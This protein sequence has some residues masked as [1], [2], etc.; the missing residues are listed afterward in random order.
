[1]VSL[2]DIVPATETVTVQGQ[3]VAVQGV[4]ATGVAHLLGRF[5]EIRAM[6][7]GRIIDPDKLVTMGGPIVAAIIAAGCG[8]AGNAD[9]ERI[10]GSLGVDEQA[11]LLA[12]ILR[13][14]LPQGVGPFVEK[15]TAMGGLLGVTAPVSAKATATTSP[16]PSSS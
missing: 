3:A 6:L 1:M 10:A 15:L 2:L 11:D 16:E 8:H 9:A 7:A 12:V 5:A 4:S 14:T 13:L